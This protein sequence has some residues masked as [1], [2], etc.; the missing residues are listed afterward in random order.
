MW[1]M[2]G[3]VQ[4]GAESGFEL[5]GLDNDS[6]CGVDYLSIDLFV[7]FYSEEVEEAGTVSRHEGDDDV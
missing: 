5:V 6:L 2:P 1:F 4:R 7:V 3:Y